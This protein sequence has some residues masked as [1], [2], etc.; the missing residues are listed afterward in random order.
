[1]NNCMHLFVH[2]CVVWSVPEDC[3]AAGVGL[4]VG[5]GTLGVEPRVMFLTAVVKGT[6]SVTG[7]RQLTLLMPSTQENASGHGFNR[8]SS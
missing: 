3:S 6:A 2:A 1:M 8:Q 5:V 7:G 4:S